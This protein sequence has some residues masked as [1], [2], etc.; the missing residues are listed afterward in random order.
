MARQRLVA[1]M[2]P[3]S[4]DMPQITRSRMTNDVGMLSDLR[5]TSSR[6]AR[7]SVTGA[8]LEKGPTAIP[9]VGFHPAELGGGRRAF[10][11]LGEDGPPTVGRVHAAEQRRHAPDHAVEDD[12]RRRHVERS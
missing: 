4:A 10:A 11:V 5:S 6:R 9:P 8:T 3:S 7:E 1:F 2:R 12:E